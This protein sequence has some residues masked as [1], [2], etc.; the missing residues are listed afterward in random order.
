MRSCLQMLNS[1][2]GQD[3]HLT[4]TVK[5]NV[6]RVECTPSD[7][8]PVERFCELVLED[9][10]ASKARQAFGNHGVAGVEVTLP[11][12]MANRK[13]PTVRVPPLIFADWP[14]IAEMACVV[15][16]RMTAGSTGGAAIKTSWYR[17]WEQAVALTKLCSHGGK[18]GEAFLYSKRCSSILDDGKLKAGVDAAGEPRVTI[19]IVNGAT[20]SL[21]IG[22]SDDVSQARIE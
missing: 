22:A 6:P 8:P 7:K 13:L 16:I 1:F 9:M 14:M 17:I 15:T 12:N 20:G 21:A 2:T 5:Q 10:P 3:G 4:V 19:S 18:A 11:W